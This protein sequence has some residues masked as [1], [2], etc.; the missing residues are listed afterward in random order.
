[1]L[2][3]FQPETLEG[4]SAD[5]SY[6]PLAEHAAINAVTLDRSRRA[7][8]KIAD[9]AGQ[10]LDSLKLLAEKPAG[11]RRGR[12]LEDLKV[13]VDNSTKSVMRALDDLVN[14]VDTTR[15]EVRRSYLD[16][17]LGRRE[18]KLPEVV[19]YTRIRDALDYEIKFLTIEYER[20][21]VPWLAA[22]I[23]ELPPEAP[24]ID[25]MGFG[26]PEAPPDPERIAY[27]KAVVLIAATRHKF[28][29]PEFDRRPLGDPTQ[30]IAPHAGY[31]EQTKSEIAKEIKELLGTA[32]RPGAA[33]GPYVGSRSLVSSGVVGL[34]RPSSLGSVDG[35]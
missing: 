21:P 26:E 24:V 7:A 17:S 29:V 2:G 3:V 4:W 10:T 33:L 19:Q 12:L 6:L 28:N 23:G 11:R 18:S 20:A 14:V 30:E 13:E 8:E 25:R 35:P 27:G 32:G 15:R 9:R 5:R 22:Q 1:M 31:L 34:E 16:S